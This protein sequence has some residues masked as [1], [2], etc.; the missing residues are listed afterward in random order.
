MGFNPI[1]SIKENQQNA[2]ME[3]YGNNRIVVTDCR[4]V[5]DFAEDCIVLDLGNINAK[6]KGDSLVLSSFGYGLTDVSGDI[7]SIEFERV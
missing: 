5:L 6:I 3:L 1:K 7:V 4:C 2:V